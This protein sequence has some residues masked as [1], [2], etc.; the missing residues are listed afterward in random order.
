MFL[1]VLFIIT[2]II[3]CVTTYIGIVY[4][5]GVESVFI[6]K[7][8]MSMFGLI[9]GLAITKIMI[10]YVYYYG[11]KKRSLYLRCGIIVIFSIVSIWNFY[12]INKI[13]PIF[14]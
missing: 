6:T 9:G 5:G 4:L 1:L 10:A 8:L 11:H 12:Q 3:D 14:G 2:Q 7:I 13:V